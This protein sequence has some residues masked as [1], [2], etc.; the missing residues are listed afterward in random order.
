MRVLLR[1]YANPIPALSRLN[2]F[3]IDAQR[4]DGR[5]KDALVCLSLALVNTE[6]GATTV[7]SA[8]ME[9]PLVVRKNGTVEEITV[10]GM[11]IGMSME[12]HYQDVR[13]VLEPGDMLV[14]ATD[15]ITEARSPRRQFFGY[16]DL[17]EAARQAAP[18]HSLEAIGQEI[19]AR[20]KAFAGGKTQDDICLLTARRAS[21]PSGN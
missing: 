15:G 13:L 7:T 4:L 2:N 20:A 19:V 16:E 5:D 1:E 6:T 14:M 18:L 17:M 8:G 9:P 21:L 12:A 3:L 11:M 10:N